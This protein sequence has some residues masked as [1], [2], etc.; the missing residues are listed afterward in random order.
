M[1]AQC[2]KSESKQTERMIYMYGN[3]RELQQQQMIKI[4]KKKKTNDEEIDLMM[5]YLSLFHT[6]LFD[7]FNVESM[8]SR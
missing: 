1:S 6:K 4:K 2:E 7:I 8:S 5:N 3:T